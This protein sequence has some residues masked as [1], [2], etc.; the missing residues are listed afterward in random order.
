MRTPSPAVLVLPFVVACSDAVDPQKPGEPSAAVFTIAD[1]SLWAGSGML[2]ESDAFAGLGSP[3]EVRLDG[4]PLEVSRIGP[5]V[6]EAKLPTT[7]SGQYL[8]TISLGKGTVDLPSITVAGFT[9]AEEFWFSMALGAE[10]MPSRSYATLVGATVWPGGG[11]LSYVHLDTGALEL[12]LP[13]PLYDF[14]RLRTPGASY[15]SGVMFGQTEDGIQPLTV[16]DGD[17]LLEDPIAVTVARQIAELAEGVYLVTSHHHVSISD[18]SYDQQL[19]E[20]QGIALSHAAGRATV[21]GGN[22]VNIGLPVFTVPGGSLAFLLTEVFRPTAVEFSADGELLAVAGAEPAGNLLRIFR[23]SDGEL[24]EE[25]T[26]PAQ[27]I[28]LAFDPVRPLLYVGLGGTYGGLAAVKPSLMVF[29]R[30]TFSLLGHLS[31]AAAEL[32]CEAGCV[33]AEIAVSAEPAVYLAG[34]LN[35]P[36]RTFRYSIPEE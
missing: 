1:R 31:A 2:I 3:P 28:A 36:L 17:I 30:E 18:G 32:S 21:W 15:R 19:E 9:R 25:Q 10:A 5:E 13:G 24:L 29:D 22:T 8:P 35:S 34:F 11:W 7:A 27:P 20:S 23:A 14:D 16:S 6:F 12:F 4:V 26:L 33:E